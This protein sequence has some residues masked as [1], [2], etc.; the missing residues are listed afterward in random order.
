MESP[1][2][3]SLVEER[4]AVRSKEVVMSAHVRRGPVPR[5]GASLVAVLLAA[6]LAPGCHKA[7]P[8]AG[9]LPWLELKG[10]HIVEAGTGRPV[11]LRG[12]NLA[13]YLE[14]TTPDI[15][16]KE[17]GVEDL[18]RRGV[19]LVRVC[20]GWNQV[21][22][23][24]DRREL[25]PGGLAWLKRL[26]GWCASSGIYCVLDMHVPP[27][28][29]DI[30][31][32]TGE[33]WESGKN[34]DDLVA[35]WKLL[36]AEFRFEPAVLGY[37]VFNE[38]DPPEPGMW[39]TL[40]RRLAR[41]LK[42]VDPR[43]LVIIE[44]GASGELEDLGEMGILYS[45]HFY[46]PMVVSHRG[47]DW[48]GDTPA[49]TDA[50]YPEDVPEELKDVGGAGP[51]G[52]LDGPTDRWKKVAVSA[53][54]PDG[55]NVA[56]IDLFCSEGPMDVYFD[57]ITAAVNGKAV[58]VSNGGMEDEG[59]GGGMPRAWFLWTESDYEG[60]R[61]GDARTGN[62]SLRVNGS[63]EWA[64]VGQDEGVQFDSTY[65]RVRPG[66]TLEASAWMRATELHGE[67]GIGMGWY[68][69]RRGRWSRQ[70]L[71]AEFNRGF[72]DWAVNHDTPLFIGEFGCMSR[73]GDTSSTEL[74]TDMI[75][76]FNEY[77]YP[78]TIWCY[79]EEHLE[80]GSPDFTFGLVD[81]PDNEAPDGDCRWI[82]E[83]AA[84][85]EAGLEAAD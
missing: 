23:L 24:P 34:A 52:R 78:W 17:S 80:P 84:P 11:S 72:G 19:T 15:Y 3:D 63:G 46:E 31:P 56:M 73:K 8:R 18:A 64:S 4:N 44:A 38:P 59:P 27:G 83:I 82:E 70:K 6:A 16:I 49:R 36:A 43:H 58:E 35:L 2:A 65:V 1:L 47:E 20:F 50:T 12:V 30:D 29:E 68:V 7:T 60:E 25:D 75:S 28:D 13:Y 55:A 40:A 81:C 41:V 62:G 76:V 61:S 54:V 79:R 53:T 74:V 77:G 22:R 69:E 51:G 85:W 67:A 39:W 32:I 37:D 45:A 21:S 26:V 14:V 42:S 57:D 66:D 10:T 71:E 9:N 5:V 33:F 48:F